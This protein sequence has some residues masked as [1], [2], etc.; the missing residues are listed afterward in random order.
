MDIQT[1]NKKLLSGIFT[2]TFRRVVLYLI[3]FVTIGL[4]LAS[5]LPPSIIGIFNIANSILTFFTFFSDIGLAA[6]IIQKKELDPDDLRTTFT[7]QELLSLLVTLVVW[8]A[9]PYLALVYHLDPAGMWLIRALSVSF[10]LTSLKV[11]PAVL[12]ERELR[13]KPLVL[14]EIVETAVFCILL[15]VLSFSGFGV[16]AFSFAVLLQSL[17]GVI[18]IYLLAPWKIRIG[19]SKKAAQT[20][21]N[22]GIPFQL[23]SLLALLKDRLVPLVIAQMVG[24]TGVGYITWAQNWAFVPLG[25]MDIM[26]RVTFPA[27]SRLQHDKQALKETVQRSLFLTALVLYPL[28]AGIMAMAPSMVKHVVLKDWGPALPLIYFFSVNTFWAALSTTFTNVLNAI[29]KIKVT[30]YLMIM[31]TVLTWG[32]TPLFTYLYGFLGSAIASAIIAF[33]SLIPIIFVR[34]LLKLSIL[35]NIFHPLVS[36]VGMGVVTFILAQRF[37]YDRVSFF[38]IAVVGMMIYA[39]LIWLLARNT[40]IE[41]IRN[42]RN[43]ESNSIN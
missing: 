3:R 22:F 39:G 30:L 32:L 6:A 33:T 7:I 35:P 24:S 13:F 10:F 18:L 20:L 4:I 42:I 40:I 11:L 9:A 25:V 31:W 36:A 27:Y 1:I 21:L 17:S 23:N 43:E 28:L 41:N 14:I 8:V 15:V 38:A 34:N 37:V 12:L 26:I 19:I 5:I 16:K 29:G 2:L